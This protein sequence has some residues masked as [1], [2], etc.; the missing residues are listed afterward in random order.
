MLRICISIFSSF[1]AVH[2]TEVVKNTLNPTWM[3]F[4]VSA[5]V[6]CN[7]DLHR[8]IKVDCF[9]WDSDGGYVGLFVCVCVDALPH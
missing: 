7:G 6:L 2:K 8:V 5:R 4:T 9:D 1:T 3:P